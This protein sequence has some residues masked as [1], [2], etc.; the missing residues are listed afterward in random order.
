[1]TS[2]IVKLPDGSHA[3]VARILY[4]SDI[5]IDFIQGFMDTV[6]IAFDILFD[7][8]NV[9]VYAPQLK[10]KIILIRDWPLSIDYLLHKSSKEKELSMVRVHNVYNE[11][12]KLIKLVKLNN[13][14]PSDIQETL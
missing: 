4:V 5:Y 11:Y 1:M 8:S 12:T 9:L 10:I 7:P 6:N 14:T 3:N 13:K 2:T